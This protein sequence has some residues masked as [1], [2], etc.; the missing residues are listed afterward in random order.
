M[1]EITGLKEDTLR[2]HIRSNKLKAEKD[3][4]DCYLIPES[5]VNRYL[6]EKEKLDGDDYFNVK[7]LKAL[8]IPPTILYDGSLE[9]ELLCGSTAVSIDKIKKWIKTKTKL[10]SMV[11]QKVFTTVQII[12]LNGICFKL[13]GRICKICKKYLEEHETDCEISYEK[14]CWHYSLHGVE[15]LNNMEIC[16]RKT[17]KIICTGSF[18]S[19][20]NAE[21]CKLL[22]KQYNP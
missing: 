22:S 18:S 14:E 1:S 12:N 9:T 20:L 19:E 7:D 8:R 6:E 21:L 17:I 11:N 3:I 15:E 16:C 10:R 4:N 5:E 13:S 2:K